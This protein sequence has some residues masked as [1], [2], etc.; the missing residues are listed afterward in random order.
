MPKILADHDVEGQLAVLLE[1]WT[2]REWR[3]LWEQLGGSVATFATLGLPKSTP[4]SELWRYC[5]VNQFI[6][7]TGNRNDD[8]DTS[9]E[10]TLRNESKPDSLPVFTIGIAKKVMLDRAYAEAVAVK[11]LDFLQDI[12]NLRGTR[13]LFLP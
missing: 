6:L 4:D 12:D 7:L 9:L 2:A 5:Q 13:R 11:V 1:I 8:S 3:P 10:S